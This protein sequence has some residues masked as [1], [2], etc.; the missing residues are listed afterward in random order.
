MIYIS[1][2]LNIGEIMTKVEPNKKSFSA[3]VA[4]EGSLQSLPSQNSANPTQADKIW[5]EIK[6]LTINLYSLPNQKVSAYCS[7]LPISDK[8]LYLTSTVNAFLPALEASIGPKYLVELQDKY[9]C[10]KYAE[11]ATSTQSVTPEIFIQ[12][13]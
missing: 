10:V 4:S 3:V 11:P 7:V 1:Y 12:S 6:D 2:K 13:K 9:I 5:S 8:D